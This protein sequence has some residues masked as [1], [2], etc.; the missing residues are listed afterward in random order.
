VKASLVLIIAFAA[1]VLGGCAFP[2]FDPFGGATV[3]VSDKP[4]L[5][6][7]KPTRLTPAE[8]LEVRGLTTEFCVVLSNDV[9]KAEEP[10]AAI[11]RLTGGAK[12]T[13]LLHTS[14]GQD[15][16]WSCKS[17]SESETASG[18][19][20]LSTCS[21]LACSNPKAAKGTKFTS[22]DLSSDRPVRILGAEWSST[23]SFDHL[24]QPDPD[25]V[26]I[27][28][29]SYRELENTYAATPAWKTPL[30]TALQVKLSQVPGRISGAT[31][32]STLGIR[33]GSDAIQLQP[34]SLAPGMGVVT[35][36]VAAVA[37]CSMEC[38]SDG[39]KATHLLLPAKGIDIEFLNDPAVLEWCW[40]SRI[41]MVS[42]HS[43]WAWQDRGTALPGIE[44][45]AEQLGS[46]ALYDEAARRSCV[47]F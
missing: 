29:A 38:V 42:A 23:S 7:P 43:R 36:P 18:T 24:A 20:R 8:P 27:S 5:I 1:S 25:P 37:A 10:D 34:V 45:Y 15:F 47:G 28:S 11:A 21:R 19:M 39:A 2:V 26:A 13:A 30:R 17:W 46:R 40:N 32:N 4:M 35:L 12:I 14:G 6:G 3:V 33:I 31:Y 22:I 9:S 44:T 16:A 41:P